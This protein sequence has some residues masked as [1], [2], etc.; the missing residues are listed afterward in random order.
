M[1]KNKCKKMKIRSL[2]ICSLIIACNLILEHWNSGI[3]AQGQPAYD[4]KGKRDPFIPLVT[5][6]GRLLKL[7][8]Q[9]SASGLTLE[10]II[11]DEHG[12]SYAIVNGEVVRISDKVGEYQVLKI[13]KN[14]VIF[15]KGAETTEVELKE[16]AN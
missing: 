1:L 14:K 8:S 15:I 5:P 10:G 2:V 3:F 13:Q 6:D 9:K 16:D 4:S 11:Y 7:E 12:L